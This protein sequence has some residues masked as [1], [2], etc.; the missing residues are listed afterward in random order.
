MDGE[1]AVSCPVPRDRVP[2]AVAAL[3]AAGVR[4]FGVERQASTREEIFLEV[5][6]GETV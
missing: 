2:E 5:T 6:S 1:E 4:G 3:V